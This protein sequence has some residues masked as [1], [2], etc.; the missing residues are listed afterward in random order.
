MSLQEP[1]LKMSKSHADPRSRILITDSADEIHR[2]VMSALTDS[3]NSVSYDPEGRPGVSNLLHLW[4]HFDTEG[5]SPKDLALACQD[6]N[7]RTFKTKVA[8]II[9]AALAPIRTRYAQLMAEDGGAYIDHVEEEGAKKA[10][11]SADATMEI[12]REAVGL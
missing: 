12:V 9:A 10:R 11:E 2:K 1:H 4:S 8:E 3:T 7:L 6:M 5:R